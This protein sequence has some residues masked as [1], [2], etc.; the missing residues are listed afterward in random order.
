M[1]KSIFVSA[2]CLWLS[3]SG[4]ATQ[5]PELRVTGT[6]SIVVGLKLT[7]EMLNLGY[8]VRE[9]SDYLIVFEKQIT[10]TRVDT[11]S[12]DRY[13]M[14]PHSRVSYMLFEQD[15][16]VRVVADLKVITNPGTRFERVA[17]AAQHP[18]SA[19]IQ[20]VL[21]KVEHDLE[22]QKKRDTQSTEGNM[23][24]KKLK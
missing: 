4:C 10:D 21:R 15:G 3:I 17:E 20:G 23:S 7:N 24:S 22:N 11:W 9:Q 6:D 19:S 5:R 16:T 2:L 14:H 8:N 18:D 12:A 13:D 1:G